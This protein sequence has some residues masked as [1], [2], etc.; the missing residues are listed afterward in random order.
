M[1]IFSPILLGGLLPRLG[2]GLRDLPRGPPRNGERL[3]ENPRLPPKPP[4]GGDQ[5]RLCPIYPDLGPNPLSL[6]PLKG[7]SLRAGNF[8]VNTSLTAIS[9][10]SICPVIRL[11]MQ[12]SNLW[13][14]T[15]IHFFK[16][17]TPIQVCS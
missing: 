13:C 10:P 12:W 3:G 2:G 4:L 5:P 17:N 16:T 9:C 8:C 15:F 7:L 1:N 6:G 11:N 14:N